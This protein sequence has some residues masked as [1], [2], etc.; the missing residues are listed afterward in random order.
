MRFLLVGFSNIAQKRVLPALKN[1]AA[2]KRIDVAT[3][4]NIN[5]DVLGEKQG[6]IFSDYE[7]AIGAKTADIA[8]VSLINSA[9]ELWVEKALDNGFHVIVDKPAFLSS[10]AAER[11]VR[12]AADKELCLAEAV[13]FGSHPQNVAIRNAFRDANSEPT[14]MTVSFSFPPL[15]PKDF[16]NFRESGGGALWDLGPYAV[17]TGREFFGSEPEEVL[18]VLL[19]HGAA[20][21]I[22]TAFSVLLTYPGGKSVVGQFG[23]DT[24]YRNCA[25]IFGP[26]MS[27]E[28][29]RFFTTT[30]EFRNRL[31]IRT[32]NTAGEV[33]VEAG[34]SF[35][36]FVRRVLECIGRRDWSALSAAL[37]R[38]ARVIQKL[39]Q[40][41][42]E[43]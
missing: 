4:K 26:G 21:G 20:G 23:F 16:R 2:V 29:D 25:N 3:T 37:L 18:G 34:D 41:C 5:V 12:L 24:E 28:V 13:V 19:S 38:D 32:G 42:G 31:R 1:I 14:R 39:R 27:V 30:P 43:V 10:H 17:A 22:D 15:N 36:L 6:R 8:Y 35:E 40:S 33:E 9:H 7:E 11:L